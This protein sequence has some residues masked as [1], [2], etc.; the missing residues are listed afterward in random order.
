MIIKEYKYNNIKFTKDTLLGFTLI[1]ETKLPNLYFY[2]SDICDLVCLDISYLCHQYPEFGWISY[3]GSYKILRNW[4]NDK[5]FDNT[6]LNYNLLGFKKGN[7]NF[8]YRGHDELNLDI[9]IKVMEAAET[10][11]FPYLIRYD[12]YGSGFIFDLRDVRPDEKFIGNS[13]INKISF[14]YDFWFNK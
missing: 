2:R 6:P 8:F 9:S 1:I 13:E 10:S 14:K 7:L 12:E 4:S 3:P 11:E 5:V